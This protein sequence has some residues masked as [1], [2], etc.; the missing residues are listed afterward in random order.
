MKLTQ[1]Q[2][3][4][5]LDTVDAGLVCGLGKREPGKMCVEAAV[6]Y[7]LGLPHSDDPGCV[8]AAV[9]AF[10]IRLNDSFWSSGEARARGLRKLAIA[11]IG[12]DHLDQ[13][14]FS[15]KLALGVVKRLLPVLFRLPCY[16]GRF[17]AYAVRCAE[18]IDLVDATEAADAAHAS[19]ATE[20]ADA[21]ARA[22]TAAARA[23]TAAARAATAA[24]A[25]TF[26]TLGAQ[27]A[28]DVLIEMK[29]PGCE[30]LVLADAGTL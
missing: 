17:E 21:A 16:T 30:W 3:Q 6:C 9:R 12:S 27:I 29:S 22:A 18:V 26:L 5:I 8:G 24:G 4:A 25:D 23:A 13:V 2:A 10:K 11:Q 1:D 19:Y 7:A 14:E 20:A 15:K 28:L